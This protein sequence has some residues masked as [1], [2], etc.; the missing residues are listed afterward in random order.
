MSSVVEVISCM[1]EVLADEDGKIDQKCFEKIFVACLKTLCV[2]MKVGDLTLAALKQV[3]CQ[4]D[5][6]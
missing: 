3:L 2:A 5:T 1:V 4:V 6:E